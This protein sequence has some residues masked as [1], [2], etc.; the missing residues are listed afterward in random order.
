[1]HDRHKRSVYKYSLHVNNPEKDQD[2]QNETVA[3]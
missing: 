1:M 2:K 3:R